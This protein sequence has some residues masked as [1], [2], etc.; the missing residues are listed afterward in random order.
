MY[1]WN[2]EKLLHL[3]PGRVYF[4]SDHPEMLEEAAALGAHPIM[5]PEELRGHDVPSIPIF[6]NIAHHIAFTPG[7]LIHMQ[8]NSPSCTLEALQKT[9][10]IMRHTSC[11]ELITVFPETHEINSSLWAFSYERLMN[12]GDPYARRMDVLLVDPATDIHTKADMKEA[13]R[14]FRVPPFCVRQS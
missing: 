14:A 5:R 8:A 3:L 11:D 13:A 9:I 10:D 4:E 1:M 7:A 6:Q 2:L 12:Y